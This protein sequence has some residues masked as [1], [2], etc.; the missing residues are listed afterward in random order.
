MWLLSG[1][2][3]SWN[4]SIWLQTPLAHNALFH[5]NIRELPRASNL[6][7]ISINSKVLYFSIPTS[8]SILNLVVDFIKGS[9][10]FP[11]L[12]MSTWSYL[13]QDGFHPDRGISIR[14]KYFLSTYH[15]PHTTVTPL[16]SLK[17]TW[18][19]LEFQA[20]TCFSKS[21]ENRNS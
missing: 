21:S 1:L 6:K 16:S 10:D 9:V 15:L 14:N 20:A 8:S 5:K 17:W 4:R 11:C 7:S 3:R 13:P 2:L 19:L 12:R 18:W